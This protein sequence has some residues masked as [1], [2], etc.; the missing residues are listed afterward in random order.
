MQQCI[1]K[2]FIL[3][4]KLRWY[5]GDLRSVAVICY[6]EIMVETYRHLKIL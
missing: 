3:S 4:D 6:L 1:F 5:S 2:I